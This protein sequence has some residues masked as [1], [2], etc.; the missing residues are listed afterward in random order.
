M[1]NE[2]I[3]FCDA[4]TSGLFDADRFEI[5]SDREKW[6]EILRP[7]QTLQTDPDILTQTLRTQIE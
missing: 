6:G 7:Y 5:I 1:N 2:G 4:R 3:V